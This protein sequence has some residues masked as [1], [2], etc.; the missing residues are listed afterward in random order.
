MSCTSE[1][2]E[3]ESQVLKDLNAE[4]EPLLEGLEVYPDSLLLNVL[5]EELG[6]IQDKEKSSLYQ[7]TKGMTVAKTNR[8]KIYVHYMPWFQSKDVDGYWGQHWTMTNRNPEIMDQNGNPE[9]ASFYNPLIGPYSSVDPDLQEYHFLLMKLAG[10]DGVIFDWYGSRNLHDYNLIKTGTEGFMDRLADVDL[11]FMIMY[12]DRVATMTSSGI[13]LSESEVI[14]NGMLDFEYIKDTYFTKPN[15]G[16]FND[17]R[18]LS[19]FGP[20]HI[21]GA[22]NWN[23]LLSV[24]EEEEQPKFLT[25]WGAHDIVGEMAAGEFLW[26]DPNHLQTHEDYYT[27]SAAGNEIIV[28]G[29]YP[30]FKSF[31]TQ[32]GW[33]DGSND[34]TIDH[35]NTFT[36]TLNF[37]HHEIADFIQI[38]TWNDFGEGTM[39]EPT[40]QFGFNYLSEIQGYTGVSYTS[41]DMQTIV[42]LYNTRKQYASNDQVQAL[43]NRSYN[44]AKGL[45]IRRVDIIL[46]A[47]ER[48]Y[49]DN[50]ELSLAK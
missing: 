5:E 23:Q 42:D 26:V 41:Q 39:V 48:F 45:R 17:S 35:G 14:A 10:I 29:V 19:V 49:G 30:G 44:Y 27:Y 31:Y 36:E 24:F 1:R 21:Y 34:W 32:G 13:E 18:I 7:K 22:D 12:E 47:I 40:T 50:T 6:F 28:G 3:E 4:Q 43:L 38:I 2:F 33:S 11:D 15:Y 25:L 16:K 46:K 37:T 9:I 8:K 20:H